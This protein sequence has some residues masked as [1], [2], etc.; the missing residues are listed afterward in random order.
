MLIR[1]TLADMQPSCGPWSGGTDIVV[2]G[3]GL[4]SSAAAA[5]KFVVAKAEGAEEGGGEYS[6]APMK[7]VYDASSS[8]L[9][10][11]TRAAEAIG[12][13]PSAAKLHFTLDGVTWQETALVFSLYSQTEWAEPK[14][15]A[16]VVGTRGGAL[17]LPPAAGACVASASVTVR[18][19]CGGV[20]L[21]EVG[22]SD[23]GGVTVQAP[24]FAEAGDYTVLVALNGQQVN[25][26]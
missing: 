26:V 16:F 17:L 13:D 8:S 1:Y 20:Q 22:S 4:V 23:A 3:E 5:A 14:P 19:V 7:C 25:V 10:L 15:K 9:K 24:D 2:A 11:I 12:L 6:S 21:E 18:F